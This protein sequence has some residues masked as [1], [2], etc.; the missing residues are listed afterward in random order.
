MILVGM[1]VTISYFTFND[2]TKLLKNKGFKIEK[3]TCG[4]IFRPLRTWWP[5][6][7]GGNIV[8]VAKKIK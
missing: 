8:L 3:K 1:V 2:L 7:L 5:E 6:L 4:G